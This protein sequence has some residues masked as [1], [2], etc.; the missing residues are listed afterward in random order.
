VILVVSVIVVVASEVTRFV[1]ERRL[2]AQTGVQRDDT[3]G[4]MSGAKG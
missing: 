4:M 1:T 2:E 3:L